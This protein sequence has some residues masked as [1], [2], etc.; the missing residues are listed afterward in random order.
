MKQGVQFLILFSLIL[1][2]CSRVVVE[3]DEEQLPYAHIDREAVD[4]VYQKLTLDQQLGM[5]LIWRPT[6]PDQQKQLII[7]EITEGNASGYML[8]RVTTGA[9]RTID[10][11]SNHYAGLPPFDFATQLHF[12]QNQFS[13]LTTHPT[14]MSIASLPAE[15]RKEYLFKNKYAPSL[16]SHNASTIKSFQ[17]QPKPSD[18]YQEDFYPV[19]AD[20][21]MSISNQH[22][23]QDQKFGRLVFAGPIDSTIYRRDSLPLDAK[24]ISC[25]YSLIQNGVSGLFVDQDIMRPDTSGIITPNFISNHLERNYDYKGLLIAEPNAALEAE[26][27]FLSGVDL[28]IVRSSV[29]Q[30][31]QS[32]KALMEESRVA[33]GMLEKKVKKVIRARLYL[34]EIKNQ[35]TVDTEVAP[36]PELAQERIDALEIEAITV[37]HN[38][39]DLLPLRDLRLRRFKMLDVGKKPSRPFRKTVEHYSDIGLTYIRVDSKELEL[40]SLKAF[41][42]RPSIVYLNQVDLSK[43]QPEFIER[44]NEILE[45]LPALVVNIGFP[46]NLKYLNSDAAFVQAYSNSEAVQRALAEVIFGARAVSGSL[47]IEINEMMPKGQS[48]TYEANRLIYGTPED[49]GIEAFKLVQ[50]D[51]QVK[52][53]L[54]RSA[55]PGCQVLVARKGTVIYNKSFG[56]LDSAKLEKVKDDHL[57]DVASITKVAATTLAMMKLHEEKKINISN[58]ISKYLP[59][60]KNSKLKNVTV[61]D[62]LTHRSGIQPHMPI[63]PIVFPKKDQVRPDCNEYTCNKKM[64]PYQIQITDDMFFSVE[65]RDSVWEQIKALKARRVRFKYSDVNF[66]LLQ[67]IIEKLTRQSL[68]KYVHDNFYRPLNLRRTTFRP[69]TKFKS[70]EIAPTALDGKWR[71]TLLRGYV[72]DEAAALQSGVGGNAGLFSNAEDLAI[73][74]QMLLNKGEYGGVRYLKAETVE[75]FTK[76]GYGNHRGLGFDK[77]RNSK[78]KGVV[79]SRVS[80]ESFGHT[81]FTGCIFWVDPKEELVFVMTTNRIHPKVNNREIFKG[82]YRRKIQDVI[83]RAFR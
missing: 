69:L 29:G 62:L 6:Y 75:Y 7:R 16:V 66:I 17:S 8:D 68:D 74:G 53:M 22:L 58:K 27:A 23:L 40:P 59:W 28:L 48:I 76:K 70:K 45:N 9:Y 26:W 43:A 72:H 52:K 25:L 78:R 81:A 15:Q 83:Y 61:K 21:L 44:L 37:A 18:V 10:S 36:L 57:Y 77:R 64:G 49:V 67:K 79:S 3:Y 35:Q 32:L 19:H 50:I 1:F 82:G 65:A 34:E 30:V 2:S 63:V 33:A 42:D 12:F 51:A 46:Y 54:S 41:Q 4:S 11:I 73:L 80:T 71:K 55:T 31:I 24:K 39:K 47:P 38:P 56:H 14:A 20:E 13:D 5:L 60:A